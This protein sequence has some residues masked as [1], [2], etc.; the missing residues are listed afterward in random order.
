MNQSIFI[1]LWY[2]VELLKFKEKGIGKFHS[3]WSAASLVN[4]QQEINVKIEDR[5]KFLTE[6]QK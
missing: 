3:K 6:E 5:V 4:F 1:V 2:K